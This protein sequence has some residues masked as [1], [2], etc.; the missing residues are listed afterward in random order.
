EHDGAMAELLATQAAELP[1]REELD[2]AWS[3]FIPES[4]ASEPLRGPELD[5]SLLRFK[6]RQFVRIGSL[7]LGRRADALEVGASLSDLADQIV[8]RL[9]DDLAAEATRE[10]EAGDRPELRGLGMVAFAIGKYGMGAMDY[11]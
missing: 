10:L 1:Q 6:A 3:R 11:G 2:I 9:A 8:D 7:D 4:P 5:R